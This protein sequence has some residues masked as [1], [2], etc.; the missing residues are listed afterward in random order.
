MTGKHAKPWLFM[1]LDGVV[2]PVPPQNAKARIDRKGPP[3]GYRTWRGALYD[4]YVDERLT[5]WAAQLD[6]VYDVIW[7]S[8]W[9][10][11]LLPVVAA[12]LGLDHWP[13][14]PIPL[15]EDPEFGT[16]R[17]SHKTQAIAK[18]LTAD[19]RPFAWCDDYLDRR[20]LP[21]AL[22]PLRLP[23]LLVSPRTRKGL[24]LEHVEALLEFAHKH[25]TD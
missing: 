2:S 5:E 23:H 25:T 14:L 4:M 12:P 18:H 17:L 7:S 10:D 15:T 20:S 1:D 16:G 9:G 13:V 11:T 22:R 21:I 24:T 19:P 3:A 6:R 8:S